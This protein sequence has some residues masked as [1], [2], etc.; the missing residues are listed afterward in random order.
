MSNSLQPH[1]LYSPWNSPG[2]NTGLGSLSLLQGIFPTQGLNPG[3]LYCRRILY[4]LSHRGGHKAINWAMCSLWIAV[5]FYW[6]A[7]LTVGFPGG[8][9]SKESAFNAGDPGF[10]PW[11][12]KIPWRREWQLTQ[13]FLPGESHGQRSWQATVH[14]VANSQAGLKRLKH[15]LDWAYP[16]TK[17]TYILAFL[18]TSLEQS[19]EL[20]KR[21][22]SRL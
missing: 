12:R 16:F 15:A 13:A 6:D 8:S 22:S 1:E 2:Q 19:S 11:V 14:G 10:N 7:C 17:I 21:L 5:T 18:F 3:L 20:S 9:D 4:E